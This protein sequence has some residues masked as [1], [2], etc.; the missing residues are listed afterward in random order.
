MGETTRRIRDAGGRAEIIKTDGPKL[1][2]LGDGYLDLDLSRFPDVVRGVG[3]DL[4]IA[5][6]QDLNDLCLSVN[7]FLV[8]TPDCLC[9]I[10]AGDG[11]R[12]APSLG[13]L[14]K[15]LKSAGYD[16]ADITDL[17]MTHL[18]GDHAAGLV[19]DGA[20]FFENAQLFVSEE[21]HRYWNTPEEH[22]AIQATQAPFAL[23]AL[24]AYRER[25]TLTKP[26]QKLVEG[27]EAVGLPGHTPGQVGFRV[28]NELPV[29]VSADAI[30]LPA[31]QIKHPEWGF[32]FD[33]DRSKA[34]ETRLGL[35]DAVVETNIRLAGAHIPFPGVIKVLRNNENIGYETIRD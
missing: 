34:L 25:M 13:H 23:A 12:R 1:V 22:D 27:V 24:E 20:R 28:G 19:Q 5:D 8:E 32:L 17:F 35:L 14:E 33:A 31:L 2:A 16:R 7:A 21:E 3:D 9:L 6:G 11:A 18:H 26:G 30:H 15:A 10:D 29:L 4:A